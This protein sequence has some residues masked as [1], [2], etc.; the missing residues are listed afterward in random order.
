MAN[1]EKEIIPGDKNR[2]HSAPAGSWQFCQ[3]HSEG[4]WDQRSHLLQLEGEAWR[5]ANQ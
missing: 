4:A 1:Y 3:R 2:L 5:D